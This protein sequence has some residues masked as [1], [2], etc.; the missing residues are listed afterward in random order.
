M[1]RL[2][3]IERIRVIKISIGLKLGGNINIKSYQE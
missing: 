3:L 2:A 1:G